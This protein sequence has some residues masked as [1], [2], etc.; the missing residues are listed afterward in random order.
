MSRI[1]QQY[2]IKDISIKKYNNSIEYKTLQ[3]CKC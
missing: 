1:K 2:Q 3:M